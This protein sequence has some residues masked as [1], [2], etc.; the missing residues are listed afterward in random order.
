MISGFGGG[1]YMPAS[2]FLESSPVRH[3][4]EGFGGGDSDDRRLEDAGQCYDPHSHACE[5]LAEK[6]GAA[7]C[8][9]AGGIWTSE[10]GG[11][12]DCAAAPPAD[13]AA[14][15]GDGP[16]GSD[17][18]GGHGHSHHDHDQGGTG[19]APQ[20]LPRPDFGDD[21][22]GHARW[23]VS[24]SLW[25]TLSTISSDDKEQPFGNVRSVVDGMCLM[26]SSGLPVFY[27]P[28]PDPSTVDIGSNAKI[29]LS[30]TEA[31]LAERVGS[32]ETPCGGKDAEDPTCAKLTLIGQ[33]ERLEDEDAI[34]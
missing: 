23:I 8:G 28:A 19:D 21:D 3:A 34:E 22:A 13:G 2:Q 14:A 30:F 9:A 16:G 4:S 18:G 10:C 17:G 27:L 12:C 15:D 20:L 25:S 31:A 24:K 7:A 5:C 1:G 29:A 32:D 6:C 11:D 33:A 26:A